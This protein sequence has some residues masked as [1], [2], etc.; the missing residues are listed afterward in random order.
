MTQKSFAP[1]TERNSEPI[2][3]VL[4]SEFR[5]A[6][7]VL[8]I[9]SGTGQHAVTFATELGHLE[10]QTS[11]LDENH[12]IIRACLADAE[13]ANVREPLLLDVCTAVLPAGSYDAAFSANTP[14]PPV[15][16]TCPGSL[17]H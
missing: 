4:R 12:R 13:L 15:L 3:A 1:H 8:E 14:P 17:L 11:D 7:C 5:Q 16:V 9:G 10:W 6:S 2:L